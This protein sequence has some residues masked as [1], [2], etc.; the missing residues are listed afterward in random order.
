VQAV[1]CLKKYGSLAVIQNQSKKM[2]NED[3]EEFGIIYVAN[4]IENY[5]RSLRTQVKEN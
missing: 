5:G 2:F 1:S 3:N 4:D